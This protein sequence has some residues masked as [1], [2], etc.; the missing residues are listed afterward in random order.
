MRSVATSPSTSSFQWRYFDGSVWKSIRLLPLL[1]LRSA[2]A[3]DVLT[4]SFSGYVAFAVVAQQAIGETG[5]GGERRLWRLAI[6]RVARVRQQRDLHRALAPPV[7]RSHLA[8]G[9]GMGLLGPEESDGAPDVG[10]RVR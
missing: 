1:S 5:D 3:M 8:A 2:S 9:G 7:P 6:R 10:G 4:R